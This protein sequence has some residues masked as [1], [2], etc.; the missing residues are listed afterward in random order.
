MSPK[1]ATA[2]LWP[3]TERVKAWCA[4]MER[5]ANPA[6]TEHACAKIVSAA[7]GMSTYLRG[8]APGLWY[9]AI[10]ENGAMEIGPSKASSFYHVVS[11]IDVLRKAASPRPPIV[12]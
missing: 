8:D 7:A 3:Q 5:A 12:L 9:E 10:L 4:M 1:H 11:A 6:D 2:K